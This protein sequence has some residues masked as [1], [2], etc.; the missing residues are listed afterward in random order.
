MAGSSMTFTYDNGQDG[1]G[2]LCGIRKVTG[3]W[4]SDDSAGTVSGTTTKIVGR[5]L[6]LVTNPSATAP[7]DSYVIAITDE[8]S[9]DVLANI[10]NTA[11]MS[12]RDTTNT[13]ELY[14]HL[15]NN[16]G[17]RI[18]IAAY[19]VVCDKLTIAISAAGNSKAGRF[20]LYYDP[21]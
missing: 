18:G 4:V 10:Q 3:D 5:L 1:Q 17:T 2:I 19:P 20:I 9:Q 12:D 8:E 16:D 14:L 13:E 6:K 21:R 7:T 15:L 11:G